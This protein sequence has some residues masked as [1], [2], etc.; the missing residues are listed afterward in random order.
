M[1]KRAK[2]E[3][4]LLACRMNKLIRRSKFSIQRQSNILSVRPYIFRRLPLANLL[5]FFLGDSI[6][7][8]AFI[9]FMRKN[10]SLVLKYHQWQSGQHIPIPSISASFPGVFTIRSEVLING[11]LTGVFHLHSKRIHMLF[12]S[13]LTIYFW[14]GGKLSGIS[15]RY[16]LS[17]YSCTLSFNKKYNFEIAAA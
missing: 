6:R 9:A 7:I 4:Q 11:R 14:L 3:H 17:K 15:R 1:F 2:I 10:P 13:Y 8:L 16:A 12:S 5:S